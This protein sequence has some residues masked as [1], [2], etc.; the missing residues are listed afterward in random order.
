MKF[1]NTYKYL[2]LIS[3]IIA[4]SL[5]VSAKSERWLTVKPKNGDGMSNLLARYNLDENSFNVKEFIALN[6]SRVKK[7][8]K[9]LKGFDY[10]LPVKIVKYNG[11]S[12]RTTLGIN[13]SET[14]QAIERYN[15]KAL[16]S[17]LKTKSYKKS[18]ELW[19]PLYLLS[20]EESSSVADKPDDDEGMK[21]DGKAKSD[22]KV[23]SD[24]KIKSDNSSKSDNKDKTETKKSKSK[25]QKKGNKKYISNDEDTFPILGKKYQKIDKIDKSLDGCVYYL[26]S[27]HGGPD[28]GAV[29][30]D[31]R[32][33]LCE[34]EYAYDVIL[35]LGRFLLEHGATVY[36][37]VE[38]PND[39]IRDEQY[40]KD[41]DDETFYD[42]RRIPN[43][44][45]ARLRLC[46]DIIND[47]YEKHKK[48]ARLQQSINIHLDSR[49]TNKNIDIF[50]YY[51]DGCSDGKQLANDIYSTI[52]NKYDSNQ[53]GRGYK[54]TI[55][56]RN[57]YMLNNSYPITVYLEL[58]NIQNKKNQVRFIEKNNRQAI[59]NWIGFGLIKNAN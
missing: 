7:K 15:E 48:N 12:I 1:S 19:V 55:S 33:R 37:I 24:S 35:R 8:G 27:G 38:D 3:I 30:K 40:L 25:K 13:S 58:G 20:G 51:K 44:Q 23:K 17:G 34:D 14:A 47:L 43:G 42:N 49:S 22:S 29:G 11:K 56:T 2:L 21:P 26:V 54:G 39:G 57:L 32:K 59:A 16:S 53:P 50:F 28:P 46:A 41:S 4:F 10:K 36:F 31:G 52:K 9:L 18:K 6:K 5:Q 45:K